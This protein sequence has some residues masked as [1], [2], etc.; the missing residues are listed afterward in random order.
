METYRAFLERISYQ[1]QELAIGEGVFYPDQKL[2]EKVSYENRFKPFYG[3]T[4]IFD[5]DDK[6]K[7]RVS[8]LIDILYQSN[9]VCL[10]ERLKTGTLHMTLHDLSA[11]GSLAEVAPEVFQ[12]EIKLLRVLKENPQKRRVIKMKTNFIINMVS[13]SLVLALVPANEAEWNK[14][15]ELYGLVDK[16]RMCGYPYLTPH[17]TLAYFNY[18]GFEESAADKLRAAVYELNRCHFSLTLDTDRLF[19]TKFVSMNEYIPVFRL[20]DK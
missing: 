12:N 19:Y 2:P 18:H 9:S 4:V 17:I 11:S 14:L 15:Q 8:A 5:L 13:M 1:N 20:T 7:E 10:S 6:T 16:V 3:D